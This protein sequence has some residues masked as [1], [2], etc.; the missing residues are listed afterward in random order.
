MKI[1]MG[2][3]LACLCLP[4]TMNDAAAQQL[5]VGAAKRDTTPELEWLPLYGVARTKLVAVIDPIY[6]RVIAVSNGDTPSLIV[7]FDAGGPP[8]AETFLVGLSK[9]TGIPI[10][11]IYYGGVGMA[12]MD[13][14]AKIL[15][16]RV[17]WTG[18]W[19]MQANLAGVHLQKQLE[20]VSV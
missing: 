17:T 14:N 5:Y 4:L 19:S 20:P 8:D 15:P 10:D 13:W 6:V 2:L 7:T 16:V 9:H 12:G 18:P 3:L 11:A 1:A